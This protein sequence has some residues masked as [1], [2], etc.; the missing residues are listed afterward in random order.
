MNP[1]KI[2]IIFIFLTIPL[3]SNDLFTYNLQI[4]NTKPKIKEAVILNLEI[5]QT[6][7]DKVI[8]FS[9]QP[10]KSDDYQLQ[11]LKEEET[12]DIKDRTHLHIK[13][14]IFPLKAKKLTIPLY[15][16]L[17]QASKEEL[18][19]FVT[20]SADELMYLQ[21]TDKKIKLSIL[22]LD[23]KPLSKDIKLVGNYNLS[24][25][26][27]TNHTKANKQINIKYTLSGEGYPPNIQT[28][29]PSIHGIKSFLSKD[30]YN[31]KLFH[32]IIFRYALFSNQSFN[33]PQ[34]TISAYNPKNK[35][36]YTLKTPNIPIT[37]INRDLKN[38]NSP[39]STKFSWKDIKKY[40]DYLIFFVTGFLTYT[41]YQLFFKDK[42]KKK[43][44]IKKIK[45]AKTAK[46][47]LQLLL[48][49]DSSLFSE[50]IYILEKGIYMKENFSLSTIKKSIKEKYRTH[51]KIFEL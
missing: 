12:K 4:N 13:Y 22:Y 31:N 51:S 8:R 34:I 2:V 29:L 38:K 17:Q 10:Q 40:V 18:K 25:T 47:L 45:S 46:E 15:I 37:I 23:V 19:K 35:K 5:N 49:N 21:T 42:K 11:F 48:S 16:K 41:F 43:D 3:L 6:K 28:I 33:I 50:E 20:G 1:I 44:F 39:N 27:D 26:L 36:N 7:P 14:A 32:K 30:R 9:F 24:Y